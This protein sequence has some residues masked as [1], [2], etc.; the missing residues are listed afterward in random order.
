MRCSVCMDLERALENKRLE[1]VKVLSGPYFDF[2]DRFIA[3]ANVEMERARS[4]LERHRSLCVSA[5][6][7][8][9]HATLPR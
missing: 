1:C 7:E 4:D 3:Y 9:W 6:R 8:S 5:I 2:S